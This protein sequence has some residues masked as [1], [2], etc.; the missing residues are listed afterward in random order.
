MKK[1]P[2][3]R[4][5]HGLH[6]L[7]KTAKRVPLPLKAIDARFEVA[8]ACAEVIIEQIFE[9]E[10][11]NPV[12]VIYTFPLPAAAAVYRCTMSIGERR[13]EA[14]VK[15]VEQARED[16]K[17]AHADGRRAA[18]VES[19]RDNLFE[20]QLGNVQPG[21]RI[22]IHLAYVCELQT[23]GPLKRLRIPVCPG[24]RFIPG[25][26]EGADGGTNLVPDAA[27][28]LP[29][30]ITAEHPDAVAFYC[31]GTLL[32]ARQVESPSHDI[33]IGDAGE[34]GPIQVMLNTDLEVPDRD[35]I[36]SWE[37]S[38]ETLALVG[39]GDREYLLCAFQTPADFSIAHNPRDLFFLLDASGSMNGNN[40]VALVEAVELALGEAHANDRF[41]I[42][43]FASDYSP[44]TDGLVAN[45]PDSIKYLMKVLRRHV[46][47][48]G[49]YFTKAF[50]QTIEVAKNARRPVIVVVTDGQFGDE[51]DA[52]QVARDCGIEVHTIGIDA[53]VNEAALQKIARRTR[54]TCALAAPTEDLDHLI[55]QMVGNLL[56]PMID[57]L[58]AGPEWKWVGNPPPLRPGQAALVAFRRAA[59]KRKEPLPATVDLEMVFTDDSRR[60]Q[61]L[62]LTRTRGRAPAILAAKAGITAHLDDGETD[63]A[64]E[65]ACR[66]NIVCEGAAFIAIDEVDRVPVAQVA[67][68]QPSHAISE[69][70]DLFRVKERRIRYPS[71]IKS[72]SHWLEIREKIRAIGSTELRKM[73]HPL[74]T[75]IIRQ[76]DSVIESMLKTASRVT[77][78]EHDEWM[79]LVQ[80]HLIPLVIRLSR[81][82]HPTCL[83][84]IKRLFETLADLPASGCKASEVVA[85][86]ENILTLL[87]GDALDQTQ[88]FLRN[89]EKL[90]TGSPT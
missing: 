22:T 50:E 60:R 66:Y 71:G 63:Q 20:L 85:H 26:P 64:V 52:C 65:L 55:Q 45:L 17:R 15:S 87:S 77:C 27:R 43:I 81:Q 72:Q 86:F 18:L 16:Y 4:P 56:S 30:R 28:L 3:P 11:P 2:A 39:A 53:N 73:R 68:E 37:Q 46:P 19:V 42:A 74:G 62:A 14:V 67:L 83:P 80:D 33:E 21:D 49:T 7:G 8:G 54:G 58:S 29:Q 70:A 10:G 32:H 84:V 75:K 47:N 40:W 78:F 6:A 89:F 9:F 13:V 51:A 31:A 79:D 23:A 12:D 59:G 90:H 1:K 69:G 25:I 5:A 24:V 44:I 88:A 38:S 76:D 48:G 41:S 61:T 35:F 57:T 34:D 36:L 82:G